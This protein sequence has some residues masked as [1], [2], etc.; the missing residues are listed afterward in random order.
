MTWW[1]FSAS[2]F[3][4]Q[5]VADSTNTPA[6]LVTLVTRTHA[7][8][9]FLHRA[10]EAIRAYTH[11]PLEWVVVNDGGPTPD[12]AHLQ[13]LCRL[14]DTRFTLLD[15]PE[16]VG[17][18][19]AGNCGLEAA[20]GDFILFH[21]DDDYMAPDALARMVAAL[22]N[23]PRGTVGAVCA[24]RTVHETWSGGQPIRTSLGPILRPRHVPLLI[25][26]A[27]RN[28]LRTISTLVRREDALAVGGFDE[29]LDVLEDWDLWLRLLLQ[30]DFEPVP[31]AT[32]FQSIRA[33]SEGVDAN[34][35]REDH[36]AREARLRNH[37][38]RSDMREGR[39][40]LGFLTNVHD[41]DT[42]DRLRVALRRAQKVFRP[43]GDSRTAEKPTKVKAP[44]KTPRP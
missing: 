25:D 33:Q 39:M 44:K 7:R 15:L 20:T 36:L 12:T 27:D 37:W 28:T 9:A 43:F 35:V 10:A 17:R 4:P 19:A 30:G 2:D 18:A 32:A 42:Q 23:A 1:T 29:S 34:T 21:D 40:G 31:K 22:R 6:P 26:I 41:R 14:P 24:C 11:S 3:T 16:T 8:P 38:L 13:A 5:A